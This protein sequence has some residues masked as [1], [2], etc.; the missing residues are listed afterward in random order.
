MT[1]T[2]MLS[3]GA[4]QVSRLRKV[5]PLFYLSNLLFALIVIAPLAMLIDGRIRHSLESDRMFSDLDGSWIVETVYQFHGA[6]AI[7]VGVTVILLGALFIILSTFLAGG[8]LAL[9]YSEDDTF[10]GAS[11]RHFPR[12]FRLMLISLV[13]YGLILAANGSCAAMISRM[14]E[15][16]M[17]AGPPT[18]LNWLRLGVVFV[19]F[20]ITNMI[21][22][23]AKIVCVAERRRSSLQALFKALRYVF[24]NLGR[25]LAVY[26][27][28]A[29]V[30]L[31][32]LATY[33]VASEAIGQDS[34]L[35]VLLIF[36]LRQV[37]MY[38][39]AWLRLW[40]WASEM[41]VYTF[42]STIVAPDPPSLAVAG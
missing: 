38:F 19:L 9:F 21:F 35:G 31:L 22:D 37:Y 29:I 3:A 30:G 26:W 42:N 40:T 11:A 8:A 33:H 2:S 28:C 15:S 16:S 39:R 1:T 34:R 36:L 24:R 17:V 23:Y 41:Y 13:V 27:L 14:R 10:F 6:P 4:R 20:G 18:M 32:M 12:L 25:T 5:I 7:T